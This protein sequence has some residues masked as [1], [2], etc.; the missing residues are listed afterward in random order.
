[1]TFRLQGVGIRHAICEA[2]RGATRLE[3]S[4]KVLASVTLIVE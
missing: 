1:M 3:E 2:E 4:E